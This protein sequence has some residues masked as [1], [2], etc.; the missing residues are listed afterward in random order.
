MWL[1][2][3][4]KWMFS[5]PRGWW[6]FKAMGHDNV[7]VLDGGLPVRL[8]AGYATQTGLP[9]VNTI[10]DFCAKYRSDWVIDAG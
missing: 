10:G 6:M 2:M 5:A 8:A 9:T 3:I 7:S 4:A 1:F